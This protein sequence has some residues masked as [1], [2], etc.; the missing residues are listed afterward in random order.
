MA[1]Y[2]LTIVDTTGVQGY[3]FGSNRLR[4][5]VGASQLVEMATNEFVEQSLDR[6]DLAHNLATGHTHQTIEDGLDVEVILRGGGNVVLLSRT[7]GI[8]KV[9]VGQLSKILLGRAPGLE[10]AVAHHTFDW[11]TTPVGGNNGAYHQLL[12]KLN[13]AKQQRHA[14]RSLLG[15]AVTLECRSTGL[16]AVD[17]YRYGP[18]DTQA[19]SAD[20]RA[21][22]DQANFDAAHARLTAMLRD[23][24]TGYAFGRDFEE[25]GGTEDERRYIA[26]VHADGNGIGRRFQNVINGHDRPADGSRTCLQAVQT[27]SRAV[28]DAGQTALRETVRRM[29]AVFKELPETF[30]AE[31]RAEWLSFLDGL[32]YD[33]GRPVLPF[34]PI[35]FGGDD[36]TFVCDGRLGLPL[37]AI[38]LEEWEKATRGLPEGGQAYACAGV[39]VVKTHYPFVR[40]YD[41]CEDL[42]KRA[43]K[44]VRDALHGMDEPKGAS[45][46][47]WHFALSGIF[48]SIGTIRDREYAPP[49]G[50]LTTRPI[51]LRSGSLIGPRWRTWPDFKRLVGVFRGDVLVNGAV[52][53]S[54]NKVKGLREVLRGGEDS[55]RKFRLAYQLDPLPLLDAR[56]PALQD[57]GWADKRCGYFDAI[58][59]VDFFLPLDAWE[60]K[61]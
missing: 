11:T 3:I 56:T 52:Y 60:T 7:E 59:S 22:V 31:G 25:L 17:F 45:A 34:R 9:F 37:A 41:L 39:A 51:W 30:G 42:C 33:R 61:Q 26:V 46:L 12:A 2:T 35:V 50:N 28:A 1:E 55:V 43:K 32:A 49:A 48:G 4:E 57:A 6:A 53:A 21:K 5:N 18:G 27:L 15:Q 38:Y 47:D 19:V 36:V 54:R 44:Q 58:E 13:R 40:A 20:V 10:I 23:A 14:S 8:A 24:A 29:V 16:P